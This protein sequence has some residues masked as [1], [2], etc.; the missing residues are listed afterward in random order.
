VAIETPASSAISRMVARPLPSSL[1]RSIE[2]CSGN[3]WN[4]NRNTFT[5]RP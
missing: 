1:I 2:A 3:Y 4:N 5:I